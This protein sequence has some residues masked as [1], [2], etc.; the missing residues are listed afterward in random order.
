VV[1]ECFFDFD[2]RIAAPVWR[3]PA[4]A[5]PRQMPFDIFGAS[6]A[7]DAL[8]AQYES[9]GILRLDYLR[10]CRTR[11]NLTDASFATVSQLLA[12][13]WLYL[14]TLQ[15]G[16]ANEAIGRIELQLDDLS[17][18]AV[19][20]LLAAT[21]LLRAV[22]LA[23]QDD[24]LAALALALPRLRQDA[25]KDAK[26]DPQGKNGDAASILCRWA[27]WKL[28]RFDAFY[29]VP[30]HQPARSQPR[31]Q[32]S[33]SEAMSVVFDL[34]LEAAVALD[35]LHMATAKRLA[36][37]AL[38]IAHATRPKRGLAVLPV[39]LIAQLLYEEGYLDEADK[40]LGDHLP[41]IKA[42]G[43]IDCALRAYVV[44]ARV[45]RQR[46][47]YDLAA[48]LLREAETL[49]EQ[50]GWPRLVA[51]CV[52]ERVSLLLAAGRAKEARS[53]VDHLDRQEQAG[54]SGSGQLCDETAQYRMLARWRVCWAEAPSTD[55]VAGLR[56]LYHHAVGQG[57]RYAGCR[58]AVELAEMLASIG[59]TE[60]ADALFFSAL[61]SGAGAGLH[62]VFLERGDAM[63]ALLRRAYD[64]ADEP[65]SDHRDILPIIASLLS[66]WN[67]QRAADP[68]MRTAPIISETLTARE[69]D[70][71]GNIS[72]GLPN[73]QIARVLEIS[74]ETVKSH[75][76][77]I[78]IKLAVST[79]AEAVSRGLSLGLL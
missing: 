34:S 33:K 29:S 73:K 11:Q 40:L 9:P 79:R 24:W 39:S 75:I 50:R 76:K 3:L 14:L 52:L 67:D 8:P 74:P 36:A 12:R 30:R 54:R 58:L 78:F 1:E 55:A 44:L 10:R 56:Q 53:S 63:G 47:R 38:A 48:I 70:V 28:G 64:H 26:M 23:L 13:A 46:Q 60:E 15:I 51:A 35:T 16:R 68:P 32:R 31:A 37:D 20:Q 17:P 42:A 25:D 65:Q 77:K 66:R 43:S 49:G 59:E 7:A 22:G 72:H 2:T 61:K 5:A 57:N 69:R 71:L 27:F 45:A 21:Q 18:A 19:E 62:Q 6:A 41:A 4:A